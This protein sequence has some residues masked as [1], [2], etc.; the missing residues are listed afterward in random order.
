MLRSR[1]FPLLSILL[2]T[3]VSSGAV[4]FPKPEGYINDYAGVLSAGTKQ[5]MESLSRSLEAATGAEV[6]VAIVSSTDG[7]P[8]QEYANRLYKQWALGKKGK[9]NGVLIFDAINERYFWIEVGYGMEGVVTDLQT[10]LIFEQVAKPSLKDGNYDKAF[11]ETQRALATLVASAAG[12][13]LQDLQPIT[14]SE[15]QSRSR[16]SFP[17]SKPCLIIIIV[18]FML[19]SRVFRGLGWLPWLAAFGGNHH[20]GGFGSSGGFG[21][22]GFGGFGGGGS[23]GG[24]GGGSY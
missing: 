2:L 24:G 22:G 10:G 12:V 14:V 15:R 21:G 17:L 1:L 13:T 5:Q 4:T 19:L 8:Y 3:V 16:R 11:S 18:V 7:M 9:D 6:A 23:G 20:G